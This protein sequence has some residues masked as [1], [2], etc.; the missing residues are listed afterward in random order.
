MQTARGDSDMD[1]FRIDSLQP[2]GDDFWKAS[3]GIEMPETIDGRSFGQWLDLTIRF[4]YHKDGGV[5][6]LQQLALDEARRCLSAASD[7]LQGRTLP[8]LTA[9]PDYEPPAFEWSPN[10]SS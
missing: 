8:E 3:I 1:L 7:A 9:K 6:G 5:E 10:P 2:I 4:K